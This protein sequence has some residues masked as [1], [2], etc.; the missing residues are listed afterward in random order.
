MR[1]RL[2]PSAVTPPHHPPALSYTPPHAAAGDALRPIRTR[3]RQ[4]AAKPTAELCVSTRKGTEVIN[5]HY[6]FALALILTL[7]GC[8]DDEVPS[9]R[10]VDENVVAATQPFLGEVKSASAVDLD[11]LIA[12]RGSLTF[13][14]WNGQWIGMDCDTGVTFLPGGDVHMFE[15][16][17]AMTGYRGTYAIDA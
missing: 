17:Y 9:E 7:A 3:K 2:T 14:S 15:Y 10:A 1:K 16:G 4:S 6:M 8:R 13:L 5:V 12:E 11:A